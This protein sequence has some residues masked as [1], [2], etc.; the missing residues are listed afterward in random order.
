MTGPFLAACSRYRKQL[1]A[2]AKSSHAGPRDEAV[3]ALL[4]QAIVLACLVDMCPTDARALETLQEFCA[5]PD[6]I[7]AAARQLRIDLLGP[8]ESEQQKE[9]TASEQLPA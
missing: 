7:G 2:A 4:Q 6:T 9:A 5:H 3:Q 8:G 1:L